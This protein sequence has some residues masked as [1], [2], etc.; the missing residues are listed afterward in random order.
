CGQGA[1]VPYSF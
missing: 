1:H